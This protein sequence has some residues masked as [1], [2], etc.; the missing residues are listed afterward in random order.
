VLRV[1]GSWRRGGWDVERQDEGLGRVGN[2]QFTGLPQETI[3]AQHRQGNR[4]D[5]VTMRYI[6]LLLTYTYFTYLTG[7]GRV[8][9]GHLPGGPVG[10]PSR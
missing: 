4:G 10:P 7:L 8:A 6:N 5:N 1:V 2:W 3:S 9:A